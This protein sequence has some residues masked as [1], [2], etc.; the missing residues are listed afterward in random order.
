MSVRI[1]LSA[2]VVTFS[3][4]TAPAAWAEAE[5]GL[6]SADSV[7]LRVEPKEKA[8]STVRLSHGRMVSVLDHTP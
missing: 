3:L 6:V 5:T 4:A 7:E 2:L 1:G 8:K